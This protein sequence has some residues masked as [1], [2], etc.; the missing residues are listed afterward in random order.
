MF[1][2]HCSRHLEVRNLGCNTGCQPGLH[3][4]ITWGNFKTIWIRRS[5]TQK[6]S[7]CLRWDSGTSAVL[8]AR[9]CSELEN[10]LPNSSSHL[11]DEETTL[12][13]EGV[14]GSEGGLRGRAVSTTQIPRFYDLLGLSLLISQTRGLYLR[15]LL[16]SLRLGRL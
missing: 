1:Q 6:F 14:P 11:L 3:I 2:N 13:G 10:H 12:R 9:S 16:Q 4:R 5:R 7:V 8:R 15:S